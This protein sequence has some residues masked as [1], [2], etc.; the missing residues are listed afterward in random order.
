VFGHEFYKDLPTNKQLETFIRQAGWTP[1]LG[2]WEAYTIS[3]GKV[4]TL[5]YVTALTAGGI[6][7]NL[8]KKIS[9]RDVPTDL[10]PELKKVG[11]SEK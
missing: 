4:V 3:D 5:K 9:R 7:R 1:R 11:D 10:F 6:D 8:W 2:P